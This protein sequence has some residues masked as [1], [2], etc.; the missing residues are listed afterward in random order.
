[1]FTELISPRV[2]QSYKTESLKYAVVEALNPAFTFSSHLVTLHTFISN[3]QNYVIENFNV[4]LSES[5][6]M[7]DMRFDVAEQFTYDFVLIM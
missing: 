5:K 1:M 4:R 3:Y 6:E 2:K 7:Q